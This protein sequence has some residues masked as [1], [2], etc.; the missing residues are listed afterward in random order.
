MRRVADKKKGRKREKGF[1]VEQYRTI[2]TKMAT[3]RVISIS[4]VN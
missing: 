3:H 4:R 1:A 2:D